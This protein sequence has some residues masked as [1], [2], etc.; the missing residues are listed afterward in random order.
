MPVAVYRIVACRVPIGLVERCVTVGRIYH[1]VNGF[2]VFC[3]A[4]CIAVHH[5]NPNWHLALRHFL[6][7]RFGGR[8]VGGVLAGTRHNL[9][10]VYGL[11][12]NVRRVVL[13]VK[14]GNRGFEEVGIVAFGEIGLVM[15]A[16]G[17]VAQKCA[18]CHHLGKGEHIL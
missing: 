18:G 10:D 11:I 17:F 4:G 15:C 2:A 14:L 7:R 6:N 13:A 1:P 9:S 16:T 8:S 12:R 3:V 5:A